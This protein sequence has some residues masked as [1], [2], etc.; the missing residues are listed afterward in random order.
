[1][2]PPARSPG[3]DAFRYAPPIDT[4][5]LKSALPLDVGKRRNTRYDPWRGVIGT[6]RAGVVLL[7]DPMVNHRIHDRN[8]SRIGGV[9]G[10][11]TAGRIPIQ[12][13]WLRRIRETEDDA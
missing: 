3:R 10:S 1:M 13:Y 2:I 7:V 12:E 9:T 6:G 5:L 11:L 8:F 4:R